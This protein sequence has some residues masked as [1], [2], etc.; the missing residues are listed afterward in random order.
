MRKIFFGWCFI[1]L[2]AA[3]AAQARDCG[4]VAGEAARAVDAISNDQPA[5]EIELRSSVI[6]EDGDRDSVDRYRVHLVYDEDIYAFYEVDVDNAACI[7]LRVT[8]LSG[9]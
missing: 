8:L 1:G 9:D 3:N 4:L 2:L 5:G 7:I 6:V